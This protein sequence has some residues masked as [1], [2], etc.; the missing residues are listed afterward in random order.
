MSP[1]P[2]DPP[3]GFNGERTRRGLLSGALI[4]VGLGVAHATP[5]RAAT[6]PS[7][8]TDQELLAGLLKVEQLIAA[9]YGRVLAGGRLTPRARRLARTVLRQEH[10]HAATLAA[11]LAVFGGAPPAPPAGPAQLDAQ[12]ARHH[13]S[14]SV[15]GLE[16]E[17]QALQL[18]TQVESVAEGAY[19]GAMSKLSEPRLQTL[20]AEIL[21]SE[22]QHFTLVAEILH[23]RDAGFSRTVPDAFVQGRK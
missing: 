13:I 11:E 6:A 19:F 16:T 23:P 7:A 2:D 3:L 12:L 4:A 17:K 22:A 1:A 21:A 20:A 8:P 10:A 15:T 9:V 5:A 14:I 18:L